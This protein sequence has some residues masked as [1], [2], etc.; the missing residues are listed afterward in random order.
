MNHIFSGNRQKLD[1]S[2]FEAVKFEF[3]LPE[4]EKVAPDKDSSMKLSIYV[5]KELICIFRLK[6]ISR[7]EY[8][9]LQVDLIQEEKTKVVLSFVSIRIRKQF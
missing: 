6:P 1:K 5:P 7:I 4:A 9:Y 2:I 3:L 8:N